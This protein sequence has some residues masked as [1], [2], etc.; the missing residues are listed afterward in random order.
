MRRGEFD[1]DS[2]VG[3]GSPRRPRKEK[4]GEAREEGEDKEGWESAGMPVRVWKA[5]RGEGRL[6]ARPSG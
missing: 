2:D 3:R 6:C 5:Q 1:G 4:V